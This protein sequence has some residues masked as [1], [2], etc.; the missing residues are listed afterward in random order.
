MKRGAIHKKL[1]V[2]LSYLAIDFLKQ[3]FEMFQEMCVISAFF[4]GK[5]IEEKRASEAL[6]KRTQTIE[7][8]S[9]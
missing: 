1:H 4:S 3:L 6:R 5:M 8:E 2:T 9:H 7:K